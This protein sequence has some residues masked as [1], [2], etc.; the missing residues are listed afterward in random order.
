VGLEREDPRDAPIRVRQMKFLAEL[1]N[2]RLVDSSVIFDM[3]YHLCGFG[4]ATSH[5]AGNI[6]TAHR[7]LVEQARVNGVLPSASSSASSS[8]SSASGSSLSPAV[9]GG[10]SAAAEAQAAG[11]SSS[12]MFQSSLYEQEPLPLVDPAA[13]ADWP[14]SCFR[15]T[16]VCMLLQTC[17]HYFSKGA[18]RLK[19]DRFLLF[20]QRVVRAKTYVPFLVEA[21]FLDTLEALRPQYEIAKTLPEAEQRVRELLKEEARILAAMEQEDGGEEE[22]EEALFGSVDE[23][24]EEEEE[25]GGEEEE[26]GGAEDEAEDL[27]DYVREHV[28]K[29]EELRFD[30]DFAQ[31]MLASLNE[32][33]TLRRPTSSEMKIPANVLKETESLSEAPRPSSEEASSREVLTSGDADDGDLDPDG[34]LPRPTTAMRL[35]LRR[36]DKRNRFVV[37]PLAVPTDASLAEHSRRKDQQARQEKAERADLKKFVIERVN[38]SAEEEAHTGLDALRSCTHT[39]NTVKVPLFPRDGGGDKSGCTSTASSR[40]GKFRSK[41]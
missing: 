10:A 39:S 30:A 25:N 12:L 35:V 8:S 37:R 20:F 32:A 16:L 31:M 21:D 29:E 1:Y 4:S 14:E 7:I 23:S 6:R 36:P 17:G 18:L 24:E 19:L 9:S 13:P 5:Q 11:A 33:K 28:Q 15:V 40:R 27:R 26:E 2:Y 38:R 22:D 3:L 41:W 34:P